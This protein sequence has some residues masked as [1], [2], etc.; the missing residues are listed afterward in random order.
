MT[1]SSGVGEDNR[2]NQKLIDRILPD[3]YY[4]KK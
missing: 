4:E 2:V 3:C 1:I